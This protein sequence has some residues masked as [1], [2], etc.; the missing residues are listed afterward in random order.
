MSNFLDNMSRRG[1]GLPPEVT[2]QPA[3]QQ[4][5]S[6]MPGKVHRGAG[7]PPEVTLQ[8]AR[9]Q[10][11]SSMPGEDQ[12]GVMGWT[13]ATPASDE[14]PSGKPDEDPSEP[15]AP[16][17][18]LVD[19]PPTVPIAPTVPRPQVLDSATPPS[20]A[21]M[22]SPDRTL[23]SHRSTE[24]RDPSR[25]SSRAQQL[26]RPSDA[27]RAELV[28]PIPHRPARRAKLPPERPVREAESPPASSA[29]SER[30]QAIQT[31]PRDGNPATPVVHAG[32]VSLKSL[33][34]SEEAGRLVPRVQGPWEAGG[35]P[36]R[37]SVAD[38]TPISAAEPPLVQVRIGRVE[39][40]AISP[41]VLTPAA[42]PAQAKLA[43]SRGFADYALA[44]RH[45]D[46][47]WY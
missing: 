22:P 45:L 23:P 10:L 8:S 46:R 9:Q 31:T 35:P 33:P 40:R 17:P 19:M 12:G 26:N 34:S 11:V 13:T 37:P 6:S 36:V 27:E 21:P 39:V 5:V 15:R 42:E 3:R 20:H 32:D 2:L 25:K 16:T 14:A 29:R 41:P 24:T 43:D 18:A 7:L 28:Q 30:P 44:R 1:A 47:L 38:A 4:L